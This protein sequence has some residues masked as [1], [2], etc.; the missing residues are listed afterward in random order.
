[1]REY[2]PV[3]DSHELIVPYLEE[4]PTALPKLAP[5]LPVVMEW[6]ENVAHERLNFYSAR[7]EQMPPPPVVPAKKG[8]AAK[9]TAKAT[10]ASLASQ[11]VTMQQQLQTVMI[12]QDSLAKAALPTSGPAEAA[13]E[14]ANGPMP[15]RVPS[16]S[17]GI[18]LGAAPKLAATLV[19]P[20]PRT[21]NANVPPAN[22]VEQPAVAIPS[23]YAAGAEAPMI[24]ALSQQ[25]MA[26]TQLVA[27]LTGGDPMVD[28]AGP[29]SS[30][31]VGLNTKGVARREKLQNELAQR[32]STFFLQVQQQL[33]R[34]MNPARAVP[35][36]TEELAQAGVSMTQ[37]LERYGG[38]RHCKESGLIMWIV[39]HAMDAAA[40][41]DFHGTKEYLALLAASMEQAALDGNWGVAYVLS[42]MEEPP[43]QVFSERM[44]NMSATGKPFAPMVPPTWA[45]IALSYLKEIEVLTSKKTEVKRP[46]GPPPKQAAGAPDASP[47]SPKRK[48]RFPKKPKAAAEEP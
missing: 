14:L 43:Q 38:Y 24:S 1:M 3:T 34:R 45:A 48:P 17:A 29:S 27:H 33:Y 22:D 28:L 13:H 15:A 35:K 8:T 23:S 26:L 44:P 41:E 42:L 9:R 10:L 6:I 5:V 39:A 4:E 30:S 16:L 7:E 40:Q 19:G 37:Y 36:T 2:D 20:P 21:K 11:L 12:Q 31:G 18:S 46:Q 47:A 25:S 32:S